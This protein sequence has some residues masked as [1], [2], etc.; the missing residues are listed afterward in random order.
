MSYPQR[1]LFAVEDLS[2]GARRHL[3]GSGHVQVIRGVGLAQGAPAEVAHDG[4]QN[5]PSH[6]FR[7]GDERGH[8][9]GAARVEVLEIVIGL[10]LGLLDVGS[11]FASDRCARLRIREVR[12]DEAAGLLERLSHAVLRIVRRALGDGCRHLNLAFS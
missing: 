8:A 1:V 9:P 12:D 7:T 3:Q 11:Q 2:A 5:Q 4:M 10:E 6:G